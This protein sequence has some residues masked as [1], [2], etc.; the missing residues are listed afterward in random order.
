VENFHATLRF[1]GNVSDRV[2]QDLGDELTRQLARR[3]RFAVGVAG[4]GAFPTARRANVIWAG[5]DDPTGELARVVGVV[6]STTA[7]LGLLPGEARAFHPHVTLGRSKGGV[8]ARA[9]LAGM[10]DPVFGTFTVDALHIYESRLGP[11]GS[12]YILRSLAPLG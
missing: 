7:E 11:G 3:S 1:L 12:T 6:A 8:D 4:L 10:P 9:A 5:V 2:I